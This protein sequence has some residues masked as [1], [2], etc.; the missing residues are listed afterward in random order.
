MDQGFLVRVAYRWGVVVCYRGIFRIHTNSL[1]IHSHFDHLIQDFSAGKEHGSID[2]G[3]NRILS[4]IHV[5]HS[6]SLDE[7]I[8]VM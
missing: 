8:N 6:L 5:D 1:H 7:F 3:F 2:Q 4:G